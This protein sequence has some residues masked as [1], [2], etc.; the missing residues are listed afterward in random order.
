MY[1]RILQTPRKGRYKYLLLS[2]MAQYGCEAAEKDACVCS[3]G[4]LGVHLHLGENPEEVVVENTVRK[5][6]GFC[7]RTL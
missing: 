6:Y 4:G 3:Y 7:Q 2:I 1:K 5:L